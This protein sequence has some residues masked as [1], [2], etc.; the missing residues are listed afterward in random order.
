MFCFLA[1]FYVSYV[2][3]KDHALRGGGGGGF[4]VSTECI[5]KVDPFKFN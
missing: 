4:K 3:S 5:K 2:A 1:Y